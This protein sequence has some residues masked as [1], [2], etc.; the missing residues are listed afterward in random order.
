MA[1]NFSKN[2]IV[3]LI[4]ATF[5]PLRRARKFEAK[6]FDFLKEIK[7]FYVVIASPHSCTSSRH[8]NG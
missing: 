7:Y 2:G 3:N 6:T 4:I 5:P 1:W 8:G